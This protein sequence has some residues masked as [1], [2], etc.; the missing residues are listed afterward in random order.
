MTNTGSDVSHGESAGQQAGRKVS[1][2]E[3]LRA[4]AQLLMLSRT[5]RSATLRCG[6]AEP[7]ANKPS[8]RSSSCCGSYGFDVFHDVHWPGRQRANIDHVAI[9]PPG[10]LVVDAKN[11]S[12]NVTVRDGVLRQNGYARDREVAGV[13]KASQ[14]VGGLLSSLGAARHPGHR[15]GRL[16]DWRGEPGPG[17]DGV[18]PPRSR[19]LGDRVAGSAHARRRARDRLAP[20]PRDA[21]RFGDL[22]SSRTKLESASASSRAVCSAT[23]ARCQAAAARRENLINWSDPSAASAGASGIEMVGLSRH[24]TSCAR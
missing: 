10:I 1:K 19:P 17:R 18:G 13:N 3:R 12:G 6:N 7:K 5:E 11:W 15:A 22:A 14:D 9:G 24:Q 16:G 4:E 21:S 8:A 20:P 2:A 23:A